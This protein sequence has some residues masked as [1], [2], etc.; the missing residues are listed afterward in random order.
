[1]TRLSF[2]CLFPLLALPA[3]AQDDWNEPFPP[4][5]VA[6]NLYYVGSKGLSTYLITSSKGHILINSSFEKTVPIIRANVERLGFR[7]SDVKILL[8]SHA[9][10][11]HVAGHALLQKLTGAQVFAMQGDDTVIR[12]GGEGQYL[13]D[14][15][16]TPCKVDRVLKDG[17]EVVLGEARL[18]AHHTPGHTRGNT[19]WSLEVEE[20]GRRLQAV[21]VGSPNVN[22]GFQ[23]VNNREYPEIAADYARTFRVLKALECDLFLGAHGQYYGMVGK[24]KRLGKGGVNPFLDPAGYREYIHEREQFYLYTLEKQS[25]P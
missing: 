20:G 9:H 25:K 15:R 17:E 7:L 22:P 2:L 12:S 3:P 18:R 1:M 23:L 4:H 8:S 24:H 10:D 14:A 19:T 11:D 13:Y 16:W 21:I 6:G 5:R